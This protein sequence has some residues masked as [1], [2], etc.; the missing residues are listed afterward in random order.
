MQTRLNDP[1]TGAFVIIMQR[2]HEQDLTGHILANELGN[3]WDH[4]CLPARY[5]I[6]HP[7]PNR[8]TLGFTDPRTERGASLARKDGRED[9]DHPRA[10]PWLLRSRRAATAA[11]K[12]QGRW[13]T[14]VKLVGAVGKGRHAR[15]YRYV[16]QSWDTAFETKESSSFS[17]RTTWGVFKKKDATAHRAGGLVGQG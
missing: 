10:Q 2:L 11:A 15:K 8:S 14:E 12:P 13:N 9:P 1:Q 5:E 16:I 7:T 4:L 17:A 3:E 6:G